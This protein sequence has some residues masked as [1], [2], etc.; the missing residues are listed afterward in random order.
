MNTNTCKHGVRHLTDAQAKRVDYLT[1]VL[2]ENPAPLSR[3]Q[4]HANW[5][6]QDELSRLPHCHTCA[7][8]P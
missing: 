7:T 5:L 8:M 3:E 2:R 1:Q 6:A 4:K